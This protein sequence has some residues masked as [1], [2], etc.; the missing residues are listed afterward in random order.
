MGMKNG[1]QSMAMA[2]AGV[3]WLMGAAPAWGGNN[4]GQAFSTW[5]DTGQT[6]CYNAK[7]EIP[8]PA[9]GEPFHGQDAQY[10]GPARSYTDLGNG[11]V[12]DNVTGLV[13]EKK[14]S[15]DNVSNYSNPHDADNEYTW[16]DPNPGTNGGRQGT[17][18]DHDTQDFI[19]QLNNTNFGGHNDWRLPTVKELATLADLGRFYPAID[20]VFAA[21]TW[22]DLYW[23]STTVASN[24]AIAWHV[25]FLNGY[26][27]F[28]NGLKDGVAKCRCCARAVRGGQ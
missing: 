17:C 6:K 3:C 15:M 14:T 22:H 24:S 23:S 9:P 19:D 5:P 20:P 13:W 7:V 28:D 1:V 10:Q 8:C 12:R 26:A 25:Y 27:Y 21:T 18:G 4:S 11:T 2:L 16:C